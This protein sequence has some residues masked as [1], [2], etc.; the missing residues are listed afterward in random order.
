MV[1][2]YSCGQS[3]GCL[4]LFMCSRQ[5]LIY[6]HSVDRVCIPTLWQM[7]RCLR[8][9]MGEKQHDP[10]DFSTAEVIEA[11]IKKWWAWRRIRHC[12]L[13]GEGGEGSSS[14]HWRPQAG[15]ELRR[16]RYPRWR[17]GK[18]EGVKERKRS[19]QR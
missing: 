3:F 13:S 1:C 14:M 4:P 6:C 15:R 17:A 8:L 2:A 18:G 7:H 5:S 11:I 19:L 12:F 9:I 16:C 10:P